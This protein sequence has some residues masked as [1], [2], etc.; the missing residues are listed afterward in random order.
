VITGPVESG[1]HYIR[2]GGTFT[3]GEIDELGG[4]GSIVTAP[5]P[6]RQEI[7]RIGVTAVGAGTIRLQPEPADALGNETLIRGS[8]DELS[9]DQVRYVSTELT[10]VEES[11]EE[12]LD[13]NNDGSLTAGDVIQVINF[14]GRHGTTEFEK[15]DDIAPISMGDEDGSVVAEEM[16][17]RRFD[18][19]KSGMISALDALI[20][21]NGLGRAKLNEEFARQ[22][23]VDAALDSLMED[24]DEDD[25][26]LLINETIGIE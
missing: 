21:I 26:T 18:I 9:V 7:L 16:R 17:L 6:E 1:R 20:I 25:E 12:R 10:I 5:G 8:D 2:I 3:E 14:L 13:D 11:D 22:S 15:L 23:Q 24:D 19:N 4:I